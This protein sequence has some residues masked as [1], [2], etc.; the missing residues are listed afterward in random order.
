[1][2]NFLVK[3]PYDL[4]HKIITY[5]YSCQSKQLC[6]DVKSYVKTKA[7]IDT[8][9]THN[10]DNIAV[11]TND[12]LRFLNGDIPSIYGYNDFFKNVFNR[13][14]MNMNKTS[15]EMFDIVAQVD[16]NENDTTPKVVVGLLTIREREELV[17]FIRSIQ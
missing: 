16:E 5:T 6:E 2:E 13:Y 12:V 10:V 17:S 11:L 15:V 14:F 1:M 4:L 7:L 3:L 8:L 9:Y